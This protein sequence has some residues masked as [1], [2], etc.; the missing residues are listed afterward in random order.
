MLKKLAI[1]TILMGSLFGVEY[2]DEKNIKAVDLNIFVGSE[3]GISYNN[4]DK[5]DDLLQ[6]YGVYI[7]MPI[8]NGLELIVKH[9]Q[10]NSSSY[11]STFNSL[12]LNFPISGSYSREVYVGGVFGT[13][14]YQFYDKEILTKSLQNNKHDG[15]FYGLH[16]GKRFNYTRNFA[17]RVEAEYLYFG[18]EIKGQDTNFNIKD[19]VEFIYAI[20]YKF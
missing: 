18:D 13:S 14:S 4:N 11:D 8:Y 17:I 20:E 12:A 15:T 10:Q 9:K 7:G 5:F 3:L 1:A 6:S 2:K 16:L 19:G